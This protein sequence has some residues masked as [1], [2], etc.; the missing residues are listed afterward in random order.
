MRLQK[1]TIQWSS[2]ARNMLI[3]LSDRRVRENIFEK[4]RGLEEEP[5]KQGKPL[6]GELSGYRS[7][8]AVG[9][10]YRIIYRVEKE[11]LM[12]WI[13][14]LGIRREGSKRDIYALAKKLLKLYL[15]K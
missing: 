8:R 14:A 12:V 13:V 1:F 2:Q 3:S 15:V 7:L 4:V 11:K 9:Q 6:I 5:E 10:R